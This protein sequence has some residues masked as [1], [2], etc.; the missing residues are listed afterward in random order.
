MATIDR[1]SALLAQDKLTGI[2]FVAVHGDQTTLD[3][4]FLREP[5]ALSP[6]L[7]LSTAD[8]SIVAEDD[9]IL[10]VASAS[11]TPLAG[12]TVLRVTTDRPGDF[13]RYRL[14]LA[15]NRIDP[16]FRSIAI[17]FKAACPSDVDCAP[18]PHLCPPEERDEIVVDGSARDFWSLRRA[19]LDF[20]N[21]RNPR[22]QDR[23]EADV[24]VMLVELLA[25]LG[26][27]LAYYQDRVGREAQFESA[28]QRRSVRRHVR[29][30]DYDLHDGLG[31]RGW[32]AVEAA[33]T[34]PGF[35]QIPAGT[36]VWARS[37]GGR[38]VGFEV[39]NGLAEALDGKTFRVN[40]RRNKLAAHVW[41]GEA[42]DAM[43][44]LRPLPANCL[45]VGA[46]SVYVQGHV[47]ALFDV[48]ERVFL[49]TE[50][51]VAN[52]DMPI[53]RAL[54]TLTAAANETD[55]LGGVL[56]TGADV[57]RLDWR[58]PL[59]FEMN[60]EWL[61]VLGNAVPVTAGV[62]TA[63]DFS[64]GPNT[65]N[66]PAAIERTGA[67]GSTTFLHT[68]PNRLVADDRARAGLPELDATIAFG[69]SL[70]R[71]GTDPR[72]ADAEIALVELTLPA[73]TEGAL[74][75]WKWRRSLIGSNSAEPEDTVFTLDDGSWARA[76]GYRRLGGEIVHHDYV[77]DA[78]TTLRFGDGE[79]GRMPP[80]GIARAGQ[81]R[82][83]RA[84]YRLG[85]GARGNLPADALRW[86]DP[87]GTKSFGD[88]GLGFI[89]SVSNPL[90]TSG[91][92]DPET[93][94][95]AKRDAPVAFR[96][97]TYRAV[98]PE[99]YDE[100]AARLAWVQRAGTQF[101]WTG[102][103][104][105]AFTAA[106]PAH[107]DELPVDR[108]TALTRYLDRYRMAGREVR[109]L[110][111]RYANL[112][113]EILICV[114]PTSYPGDVIAAVKLALL[115]RKGVRPIVGFFDPDHFTFGTPLDR[116]ELETAV[117]RVPG[118]RAV[119]EIT[120]KRRGVFAARPF[121]EPYYQPAANEVIRIENDPRHPDR[122][123]VELRTEGGA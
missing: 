66:L 95:E 48:G 31:A 105:S 7:S 113:L 16:F 101:R 83:F 61:S 116:S 2:D 123:S 51:L 18:P 78:G 15:G 120:I 100:L 63:S 45:P 38:V 28:T 108:R 59:P 4:Y 54:V 12:R 97:E 5:T 26:D 71:L 44:A 57:T 88:L 102:S 49:A 117:Q 36:G 81:E 32:L 84:R 109:V 37:E 92:V 73:N 115:G 112:D 46:T 43:A 11:F 50:P 10:P 91:G 25:A 53:R 39:G 6:A 99:D 75:K 24:G 119:K 33:P 79:F 60:L 9:S 21:Q 103:W 70:V 64:V 110:E 86:A 40:A 69:D 82:F 17:N 80:R 19:L 106:D 22:W 77:S 34:P 8:V 47:A 104:L 23:L 58:E 1:E 67:D 85:N 41:D 74:W 29:L 87:T 30:V 13:G 121:V 52:R 114:A 56:G 90:A 20:A 62:T 93:L 94:L 89:A 96:A 27:E 35:R 55:P 3:V 76:V 72:K 122:G 68:L 118:V 14:A 98:R 107:V 111:P 65:R 42:P